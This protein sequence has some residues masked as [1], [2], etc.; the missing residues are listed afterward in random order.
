VG[1]TTSPS[2]LSRSDGCASRPS[3][4][5]PA[6][7]TKRRAAPLCTSATP[8]APEW[9][10]SPIH[11][12]R[13]TERHCS[14]PEDERHRHPLGVKLVLGSLHRYAAHF[15]VK[16]AQGDAPRVMALEALWWSAKIVP[17]SYVCPVF[18]TAPA[19]HPPG[20]P[21]RRRRASLRP[22]RDRSATGRSVCRRSR[23][24]TRT[25]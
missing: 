15:A 25:W 22:S 14:E 18:G 9:S 19:W 3:S 2:P 21:A 20:F 23:P 10:S 12:G 1:S 24:R 16:K 7:P 11:S 6:W 17:N 13:C 8:M 5:R 4:S